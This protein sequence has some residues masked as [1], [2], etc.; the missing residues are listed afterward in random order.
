MRVVCFE[1]KAVGRMPVR[2]CRQDITWLAYT[3]VMSFIY[4]SFQM[5]LQILLLCSLA[6]CLSA[7]DVT[8]S[9]KST[10]RRAW[11]GGFIG[12]IDVDIPEG[13]KIADSRTMRVSFTNNVELDVSLF[14]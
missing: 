4:I 1:F 6:A 10:I 7:A 3:V 12:N 8:V 5:K 14:L 9:T 2:V 11:V 13:P